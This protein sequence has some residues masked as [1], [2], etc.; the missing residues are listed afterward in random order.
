MASAGEPPCA[1][2]SGLSALLCT[3]HRLRLVLCRQLQRRT[4][5]SLPP[6]CWQHRRPGRTL[7]TAGRAPL[8]RVAGARAAYGRGHGSAAACRQNRG[9]HSFGATNHVLETRHRQP[10]QRLPL[11]RPQ[12]HYWQPRRRLE[13]RQPRH[14]RRPAKG[15]HR[16]AAHRPT[17]HWR[18]RTHTDTQSR[19]CRRCAAS[20]AAPHSP[21]MELPTTAPD[22]ETTAVGT[23]QLRQRRPKVPD[24]I[25]PRRA[26]RPSPPP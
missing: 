7:R 13:S 25:L 6:L 23:A 14:P 12:P 11:V 9:H 10:R 15:Q 17:R 21:R 4:P 5:P 19:R 16:Q 8:H 20:G 24:G 22:Q 18:T 2:S 1:A 3:Q 26:R